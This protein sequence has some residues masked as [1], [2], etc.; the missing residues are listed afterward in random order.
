MFEVDKMTDIEEL[1]KR[2]SRDVYQ[3]ARWL[4]GNPHQAED[5]VSETFL[6]LW[7][8]VDEVKVATAK[9]YLLTIARNLY[10]SELRRA[11]KRGVLPDVILDDS[12]TPAELAEQKDE[13]KA[14]M[15]ATQM[16]PEIQR[17]CLLMRVQHDVSYE[18]I[19][20]SLEITVAAAKVNVHRARL[21]LAE[22]CKVSG[23]TK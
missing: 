6:R 15:K 16:L 22:L 13:V 10:L 21:K 12:P 2:H 23:E 18:E 9:A 17:S 14:A 11:N 20:R 8:S 1:Y 5:I 3:F 19:A 7:G 4:S